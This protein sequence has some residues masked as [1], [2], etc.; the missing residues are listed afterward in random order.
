[1]GKGERT[2][3][4]NGKRQDA[5]KKRGYGEIKESTEWGGEAGNGKGRDGKGGKGKEEKRSRWKGRS[6]GKLKGIR[7]GGT[8]GMEERGEARNTCVPFQS[9]ALCCH[10]GMNG[11]LTCCDV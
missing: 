1:M 9:S 4:R 11:K 10:R 5:W 7:R 3:K 2:G 8:M 6:G